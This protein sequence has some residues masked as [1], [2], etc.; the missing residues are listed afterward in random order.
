MSV[1]ERLTI[2]ITA[3]VFAFVAFAGVTEAA[4]GPD[5]EEV[6]LGTLAVVAAGMAFLSLV[7]GIKRAFGGGGMPPANESL[8]ASE[9]H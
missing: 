2:A 6:A 9:H 1:L 8:G 3:A 4:K 5:A 7:Y